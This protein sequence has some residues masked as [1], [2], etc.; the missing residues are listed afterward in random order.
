MNLEK[1]KRKDKKSIDNKIKREKWKQ[2]NSKVMDKKESL[3]LLI[4]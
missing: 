3:L 2:H 1:L 4:E